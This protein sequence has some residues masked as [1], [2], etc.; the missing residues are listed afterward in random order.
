MRFL[1][2]YTGAYVIKYKLN[3]LHAKEKTAN[4]IIDEVAQTSQSPTL[5]SKC[6]SG[7]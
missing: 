5:I 3:C 2:I 4:N 6:Q 1:N 7:L